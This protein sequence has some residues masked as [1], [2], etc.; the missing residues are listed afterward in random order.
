MGRIL[1]SYSLRGGMKDYVDKKDRKDSLH[2]LYE[3]LSE[4]PGV[5]APFPWRP[6]LLR[7]QIALSSCNDKRQRERGLLGE[8][9]GGGEGEKEGEGGG[10]VL[11]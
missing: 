9:E 4:F 6:R 7:C 5:D 10:E 8:R 2:R 11:G 1:S 3:S